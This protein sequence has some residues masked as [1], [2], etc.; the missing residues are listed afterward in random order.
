MKVVEETILSAL[1]KRSGRLFFSHRIF[2]R[3]IAS[4]R[5]AA[6]GQDT[7]LADGGIKRLDL[8]LGAAIHA[9]EDAVHQRRQSH[10]P[11]HAGPIAEVPTERIVAGSTPLSAITFAQ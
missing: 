11:Q 8:G 9:I 2:G 3:P 10:R 5:I 7:V 6:I 1:A 4:Q